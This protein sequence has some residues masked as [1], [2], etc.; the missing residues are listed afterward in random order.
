MVQAAEMVC[1][2]SDKTLKGCKLLEK[3]QAYH[4]LVIK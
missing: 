3:T 1:F 4:C 2:G